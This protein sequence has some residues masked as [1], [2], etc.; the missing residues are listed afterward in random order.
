[1][2]GLDRKQWEEILKGAFISAVLFVGVL[3]AMEFLCYMPLTL[4]RK[5]THID[6]HS[7]NKSV[8]V[9]FANSDLRF[10]GLTVVVAFLST[11]FW[12]MR[13]LPNRTWPLRNL[14]LL[15]IGASY[16][17]FRID[18]LTRGI[19]HW[20]LWYPLP[21]AFVPPTQYELLKWSLSIGCVL[22]WTTFWSIMAKM[23]KFQA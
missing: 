10:Y 1:M 8:L 9:K 18:Y 21:G 4:Y 20:R 6:L 16:V 7:S 14:L 22:S 17:M 15:S 23:R 11:G 12:R 3:I 2:M 13:K 19:E 5:V